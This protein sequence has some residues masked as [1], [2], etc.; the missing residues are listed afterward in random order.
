MKLFYIYLILK[1]KIV[2]YRY[3]FKF[4]FNIFKLKFDL[5][6]VNR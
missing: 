6:D 1:V 4:M 5:N 3:I 2:R